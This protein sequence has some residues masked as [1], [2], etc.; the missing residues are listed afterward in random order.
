MPAAAQTASSPVGR[1]D[2]QGFFLCLPRQTALFQSGKAIAVGQ[3]VDFLSGSAQRAIRHKACH[4][5]GD[6]L[7][8]ED[9]HHRH[10]VHLC[11]RAE[12]CGDPLQA[13]AVILNALH[14]TARRFT[15]VYGG[16]QKQHVFTGNHARQIVAEDELA[17]GVIFGRD[18]VDVPAGVHRKAVVL[19]EPP[20]E[21]RAD[22]KEN[23]SEKEMLRKIKRIDKERSSY[24]E[25]FTEKEWGKKESYHL[26]IN[27]SG[28]EIKTLVSGVME[29]AER[30]FEQK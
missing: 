30:W 12:Y 29:Y 25:L 13:S 28:K 7:G 11:N 21:E 4:I 16:D 2:P 19:G 17:V 14:R 3:C 18:D 9:A 10:L 8:G 26:C 5:A 23:L 6:V 1:C 15:G 27:T 24:R 22:E 20:C